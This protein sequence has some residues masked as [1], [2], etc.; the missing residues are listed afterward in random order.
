MKTIV[1][2]DPATS[3]LIRSFREQGGAY[4]AFP[5]GDASGS[6]F[7]LC[8]SEL[9]PF[10]WFV[11]AYG[12]PI[13]EGMSSLIL[14]YEVGKRSLEALHAGFQTNIGQDGGAKAELRAYLMAIKAD[15]YW[16]PNLVTT[17]MEEFLNRVWEIATSGN[18]HAD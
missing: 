3:P 7:R 10:D 8:K 12:P 11:I 4:H 5:M 9:P 2:Y 13:N 1:S 14:D 16:A 18:T 6:Q 17:N 15:Q